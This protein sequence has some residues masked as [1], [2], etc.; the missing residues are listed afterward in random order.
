MRRARRRHRLRSFSLL[1]PHRSRRFGLYAAAPPPLGTLVPACSHTAHARS[2]A[3]R[4]HGGGA[5][6]RRTRSRRHSAH[7]HAPTR[8]CSSAYDARRTRLSLKHLLPSATMRASRRLYAAT[9]PAVRRHAAV[10]LQLLRRA[11]DAGRPRPRPAAMRRGW[12]GTEATPALADA[13]SAVA[14]T[15]RRRSLLLA[16]MAVSRISRLG[17]KASEVSAAQRAHPCSRQRE[18]R[19]RRRKRRAHAT[20]VMEQASCITR[21]ST[22][23]CVQRAPCSRRHARAHRR[24][25]QQSGAAALAAALIQQRCG[26]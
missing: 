26:Y 23:C 8:S 7:A 1:S 2:T 17:R 12:H 22:V 15:G 4:G 25:M 20:G 3:Q 6:L 19:R 14:A 21:H 11:L 24:L 10:G 13:S 16:T 18:R 9:L 5:A